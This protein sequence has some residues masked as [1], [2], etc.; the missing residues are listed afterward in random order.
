MML[1][2]HTSMNLLPGWF[3]FLVH[4]NA[5]NLHDHCDTLLGIRF[6]IGYFVAT[7]APVAVVVAAGVAFS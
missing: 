5:K 1:K 2:I 6:K 3:H 7:S 4:G